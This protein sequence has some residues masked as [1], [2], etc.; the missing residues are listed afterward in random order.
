MNDQAAAV[1]PP[2]AETRAAE[3]RKAYRDALVELMATHDRLICLDTDTGL[4]SGVDFGLAASRYV[5]V[6]IAEQNVM[7]LAAGL[8]ASGWMPFVNTMAAFASTRALEQVKIDIAYNK[9]P[10][11][12]AASHG[13][14]S[15]GH[16]G[17][18]HHCLEDLA[19]MRAIP[20]MTVL[21]PAD[22]AQTSALLAQAIE[23]PGPAYLRLGRGPTPQLPDGADPPRLGLLQLLRPGRD[24]LI[25]AC[26]PHPSLAALAAAVELAEVGVAAAVANAHTLKPLDQA[27]LITA[28][29]GCELVVTV[30]DHWSP[31]GLGGAVAELL[32]STTANVPRRL[33]RIGVGDRFVDSV[34]DHETLLRQCGIHP[35]G[36]AARIRQALH[37]ERPP[38][39]SPQTGPAIETG[40]PAARPT[41]A[42]QQRNRDHALNVPRL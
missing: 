20:S 41:A 22:A 11:R 24:V 6:G 17:P 36:I 15:A 9:L 33:V 10:V 7:G 23:L 16:L 28:A 26:G 21:I 1:R 5:N 18:S 37:T 27:G 39:A 34:G 19:I 40:R 42:E 4:F 35:A 31:G 30:E 12:I 2:A 8:A 14:L 29:T 38:P 25:V 13:G 32:T 3:T